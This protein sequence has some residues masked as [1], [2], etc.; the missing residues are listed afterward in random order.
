[1]TQ[2]RVTVSEEA[3]SKLDALCEATG[4]SRSEAV[5]TLIMFYIEDLGKFI[6]DAIQGTLDEG[7]DEEEDETEDEDEEE[8]ENEEPGLLERIFGGNKDEED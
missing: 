5:E 4:S 1:M 7:E 2:F 6:I 3:Q 8:G